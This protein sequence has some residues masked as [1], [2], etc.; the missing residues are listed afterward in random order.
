M[1]KKSC[2]AAVAIVLIAFSVHSGE[3]LHEDNAPNLG[4]EVYPLSEQTWRSKIMVWP[5]K[6]TDENR[7]WSGTDFFTSEY[8][9]P[10]EFTKDWVK[11]QGYLAAGTYEMTEGKMVITGGKKGFAFG[12]GA[13]PG[14][15]SRPSVR[16]G[17]A[18]GP[19]KKDRFRLRLVIEQEA[20]ESSWSFCAA[21]CKAYSRDLEKFVIRGKGRQEFET[22]AG[23]VRVLAGKANGFKLS[24]DTPGI[25]VKIESLKIAPSSALV[26]FRKKITLAEKP[27]LAPASFLSCEAYDL[28]VN[29]EKVA[30]GNRI[31]PAGY[32]KHLDL[33]PYMRQGENTIA[34]CREFVS[35][36]QRSPE[37]LF[38]GAAIDRAGNIVRLLGDE[39]WKSSLVAGDDWMK[40][41]YDDG[42]WDA[43]RLRNYETNLADGTA[44][45][46]GLEPHHMGLMDVAPIG[47]EYPVFDADG[48]PSFKLRLPVGVAGKFAPRLK[49]FKAGTDAEIESVAGEKQGEEG[50]FICY[51]FLPKIREVGAYRLGW[52]LADEAGNITESRRGEM[53]LVGLI[54][55]DEVALAEFE[56]N[57]AKRLRLVRSIDCAAKPEGDGEFLD[58]GGMYQKAETNKGRVVEADGMAYRETG[59]G[60]FD[61]FAYRLHFREKGKPHLIEV[62][63]PDD[64]PRYVYSCVV[65]SHPLPFCNNPGSGAALGSRGWIS[66]TG[67][68]LTGGEYYPLTHGTK[69]LRYIY[70]PASSAAA[71]AVM[72]G[73][74]GSPAAACKINIYEIDGDLPALAIPET[75]RLFGCHNERIS[76]MTLT[77]GADNPLEI[78]PGIRRSGHRDAWFNWYKAIARKIRWLRFQGQ[79]MAVEGV[80]MY[81]Q[82]DYPSLRNNSYCSN[83]DLDV[84]HLLLRLYAKNRIKCFIG[85][86]YCNSP[87]MEAADMDTVSDRR[88]WQGEEGLHIVDR[89]GRQLAGSFSRDG[90]NFLNPKV[91]ATMLDTLGE[92]YDRYQNVGNP[93][94]LFM[95]IGDWWA[96]GFVRGSYRDV[97]HTEVGYGDL[98]VALF[99]KEAGIKLNIPV[100]DPGRFQKRYELLMGEHKHA[101]LN[102]RG[103]KLLDFFRKMSARV[104]S[105]ENKWDMFIYPSTG[106]QKDSPFDD[107]A[108]TR[109]QRDGYM[110]NYLASVGTPLETYA[111][112]PGIN[113]ITPL[114]EVDRFDNRKISDDTLPA[115]GWNT[116]DGMREIIRK[117][118][119]LYLS[120][121]LNE[122]DMPAGAADKWI[123]NH[124]ARGVFVLRGAGDNAM[125][126][127]VD[128]MRDYS[129]KVV[130]YSWLDCNMETAFGEQQRRFAKEFYATPTAPL[131][132]LPPTQSLGIFAQTAPREGGS[133]LRLVN[134][135]PYQVTGAIAG[136]AARDLVYDRDLPLQADGKTSVIVL[137]PN[138]IRMFSIAA[139]PDKIRCDFSFVPEVAEELK[140]RARNLLSLKNTLKNISGDKVARL[141]EGLQADDAFVL[142]DTLTD[143]EVASHE[144]RA[145]AEIAALELQKEFMAD[146]DNARSARID[147]AAV[148]SHTDGNGRR[149]LSDQC[150]LRCG[151]YGN[152]G[153]SYVDRGN[154]AIAGTESEQTYRT[155]AYGYRVY[156]RIPV[157]NGKYHVHLHFAETYEKINRAGIRS[158]SVKIENHLW[159]KRIDPFAEA[160]GFAKAVILSEKNLEV[161]DG[162]IDIELVGGVGIQGIEIEKAE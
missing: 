91:E 31:Y 158:F 38:E 137:K 3:L 28:Y 134:H 109:Q 4:I 34:F 159:Q 115:H 160:G 153:A 6:V 9:E 47:C 108:S 71:V 102:W 52:E 72:S 24:C 120:T 58:H 157:P 145:V 116:N 143:F 110:K 23:L 152:E 162:M 19:Q 141:F 128:A 69:T 12:F 124:T 161:Y 41:D 111:G 79:N 133:W 21:D 76:L 65:E 39:S 26:Y 43:P 84:P 77:T 142:Y 54:P 140:R 8:G 97:E 85:F 135:S 62:I 89:H 151:A 92:I 121:S 40:A 132:S 70:Y 42:K 101:W 129:P 83:Q 127:F 146:L 60:Y 30:A 105:H 130:F 148:S 139:A 16:F 44:V 45:A 87:A 2:L 150:Y 88:M 27:V 68:C 114:L 138:D 11:E 7:F 46:T 154:I 99:E 61:Y 32:L 67:T 53:V 64:K 131:A 136:G 107:A 126:H 123:W 80:Y 59:V 103:A 113:V 117:L 82:G 29:G 149:W 78:D 93:A 14:D 75:D 49:I 96:P 119:T 86:E 33:A 95:V 57:L 122:V 51:S 155:E 35:W 118:D 13:I 90:V 55:Q 1:L 156:Y 17:A 10:C 147:C 104:R 98:T 74:Q 5:G 48:T 73:L 100:T 144:K 125:H 20:D 81:D 63:I 36:S 15:F 106:P 56:E 37:W 112:Q 22:D 18:W 25:T 50:D 94:G 66:S